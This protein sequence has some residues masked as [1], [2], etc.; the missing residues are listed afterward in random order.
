[1]KV[2]AASGLEPEIEGRSVTVLNLGGTIA[3][4]YD[5]AGNHVTLSGPA[6]LGNE[7]HEFIELSPVQSNAL[8]WKHLVAL[9]EQVKKLTESG[10]NN[11]VVITG[12]GTVEDVATFL[13]VVRPPD[14]RIALLVSFESASV[15]RRAP[16]I[17]AALAWLRSADVGDIRLFADGTAFDYPFEKRWRSG[18]WEFVSKPRDTSLPAWTLPLSSRLE[19]TMPCIPVASAGVG[20]DNWIGQLVDLVP[21]D[22]LVLE[23]F[24]AGDVPPEVAQH[25]AAYLTSGGQVV[26]TSLARPGRIEPTYP[27]I[28]GT[29]HGLLSSGCYGGGVL[30]ARQARMRLAV[31]LASDV[32]EAARQAFASFNPYPSRSD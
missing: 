8:S 22:G 19:E 11:V 7:A 15:G 24:G 20:A 13:D 28:P 9:R 18:A 30:T 25:I 14:I 27:G 32:P 29:S 26:I 31:A 16:G 1:M 21:S 12:T 23:A 17:D 5:E 10:K 3:L 6:L 2:S 4:S